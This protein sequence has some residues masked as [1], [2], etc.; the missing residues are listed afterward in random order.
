MDIPLFLTVAFGLLGIITCQLVGLRQQARI[1]ASL[2]RIEASNERME[3][4]LK[5]IE[6]SNERIEAGITETRQV[7][8]E[9][10]MD[11]AVLADRVP[12]DFATR[13]QGGRGG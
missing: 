1:E 3:T 11:T 2:K 8:Q 12:R 5:R 4:S 7:Q 13:A 9:I 6:A 10:R